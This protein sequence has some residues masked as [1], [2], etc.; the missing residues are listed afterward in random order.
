MKNQL[1]NGLKSREAYSNSELEHSMLL[2]ILV[3]KGISKY[4]LSFTV[5]SATKIGHYISTHKSILKH[6][7]M[8]R[9]KIEKN[10]AK[11]HK[12]LDKAIWDNKFQ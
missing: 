8:L 6:I 4:Q 7:K 1:Y 10:I 9:A 3:K 12:A 5:P 2:A 11:K